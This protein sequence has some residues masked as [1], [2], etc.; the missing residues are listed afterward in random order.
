[1]R[2]ITPV[3]FPERRAPAI[4]EAGTAAAGI[5][6][7]GTPVGAVLLALEVCGAIIGV[8]GVDGYGDADSTTHIRCDLVATNLAT[9]CASVE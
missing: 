4:A 6:E 9:V 3:S 7:A 1:M 8:A 2:E 5:G